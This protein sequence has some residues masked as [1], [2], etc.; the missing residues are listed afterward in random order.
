NNTL[1]VVD[2]SGLSNVTPTADVTAL[3]SFPSAD[4]N[5][6]ALPLDPQAVGINPVTGRA[7]VAFTT[8]TGAG[9]SNA[10]AILDL[11]QSPPALINVVNLN[12]GPKPHIAVSPRLNWALATPGAAGSLSIVDLG[13][14]TVN[15]ITSITCSSGVATVNTNVT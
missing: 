2:L 14:Q 9:G 8:S 12:N 7:L 3:R 4:S 5:G 1:A 15:S 10:G 6:N 13:R 11:T